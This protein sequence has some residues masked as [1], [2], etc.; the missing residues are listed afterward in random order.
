MARPSQPFNGY[1][2][3]VAFGFAGQ[4]ED[5]DPSFSS[6]FDGHAALL[7]QAEARFLPPAIAGGTVRLGRRVAPYHKRIET[8]EHQTFA[9]AGSIQ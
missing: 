2:D 5:G 4:S 9:G 7:A 6:N 1:F 8:P 3:G